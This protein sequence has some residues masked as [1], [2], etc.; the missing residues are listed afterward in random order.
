MQNYL[1]HDQVLTKKDKTLSQVFPIQS[2]LVDHGH[3]TT[4]QEKFPTKSN[5]QEKIW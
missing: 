1:D 3:T 4:P 5:L 2:G